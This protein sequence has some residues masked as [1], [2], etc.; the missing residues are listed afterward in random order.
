MVVGGISGLPWIGSGIGSFD[1]CQ[2]GSV[3]TQER[4]QT[5]LQLFAKLVS[6]ASPIRNVETRHSTAKTQHVQYLCCI[7]FWDL[8]WELSRPLCPHI[9]KFVALQALSHE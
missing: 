7:A 4:V 8:Y 9:S 3:G 1:W 6:P 5:M 2:L